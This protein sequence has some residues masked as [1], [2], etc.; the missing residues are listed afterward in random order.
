M[1]W[2]KWEKNIFCWKEGRGA[3]CPGDGA[4]G[5]VIGKRIKKRTK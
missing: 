1:D 3:E 5:K 2:E 4:E